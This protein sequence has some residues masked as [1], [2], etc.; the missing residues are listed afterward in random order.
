MGSIRKEERKLYAKSQLLKS[1][2]KTEGINIEKQH[3]IRKKANELK[4]K[5]KFF[6][7]YLIAKDKVRKGEN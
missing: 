7:N 3:E 6:Q 2:S 4:N 1:L 5:Q